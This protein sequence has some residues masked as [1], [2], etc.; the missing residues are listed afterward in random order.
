M[1]SEKVF[2]SLPF[3]YIYVDSL[4]EYKL[5]SDTNVSSKIKSYDQSILSYFNSDYINSIRDD[6]INFK[7]TDQIKRTCLKC[8]EREKLGLWS[9]RQS[10]INKSVLDN[11]KAG[12]LNIPTSKTLKLKFGNVCNLMCLTCGPYTSSRWMAAEK[13]REGVKNELHKKLKEMI[14]EAAE[15]KYG[16][17]FDHSGYSVSDIQAFNFNDTFYEELQLF[18]KNLD[19][20]I[21]SGG[22]PFLSDNFYY[23][24]E[25]LLKNDYAKN[26][27]LHVFTNG[28]QLPKNFKRYCNK[29]RSFTIKVSIDGVGAK[30]EYIRTGTNFDI[31]HKNICVLHEYFPLEFAVTTTILNVGYRNEIIRYAKQFSIYP[32]F[33]N[34]LIEPFFFQVVNLPNEIVQLYKKKNENHELFDSDKGNINY[35][36]LGI[37]YLKKFDE[38]NKTNLLEEWPEFKDYYE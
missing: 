31:K 7:M 4:N 28:M 2:C 22:E 11:Y 15:E 16:G 18:I 5:C 10:E 1:T 3:T 27:N 25:W 36:K 32:N 8:I 6:M 30:D 29:F 19:S 24:I 17:Y 35:F 33:I 9:R 38:I 12:F 13:K 26:L 37:L 34:Q 21:I 23:F 20:I 14:K